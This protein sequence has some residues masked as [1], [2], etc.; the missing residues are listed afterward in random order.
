MI[1]FDARLLFTEALESSDVR[2]EADGHHLQGFSGEI[3][4]EKP[5]G[6]DFVEV[7]VEFPDL[8]DCVD[9]VWIIVPAIDD[10]LECS[11]HRGQL[12]ADG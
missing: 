3:A 5:V 9:F 4:E 11:H 10:E 6:P 8:G 7:L 1:V 12:R 2:Q